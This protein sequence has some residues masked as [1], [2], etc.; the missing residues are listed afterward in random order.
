MSKKLAFLLTSMLSPVG[1]ETVFQHIRQLQPAHILSVTPHATIGRRYRRLEDTP[2]QRFKHVQ[3][4]AEGLLEVLTQAVKDRMRGA[5][6]GTTLSGGLDSGSITAI[7][8]SILEEQNK[9][10]PAF[11]HVPVFDTS[12]TVD[13]LRF[14]DETPYIMATADYLGNVD[15]HLLDSEQYSPLSAIREK[16]T[17]H[18][19]PE[20]AACNLFWL[21]DLLRSAKRHG[22]TTLLTGQGGNATISWKGK[23]WISPGTSP[24]SLRDLRK[25]LKFEIVLPLL[26]NFALEVL[27]RRKKKET[28]WNHTAIHPDFA[29]R[30]DLTKSIENSVNSPVQ[31]LKTLKNPLVTRLAVIQPQSAHIGAF[32]KEAG[33]H[34]GIDVQDPTQDQR[35]V[36]YTLSIPNR[37][38]TANGIDR[39]VLRRAMQGLLP[40]KVLFNPRR[41]RQGSDLPQRLR[42]FGMEMDSALETFKK[43][44]RG[45]GTPQSSI[46]GEHLAGNSNPGVNPGPSQEIDYHT[47]PWS[48]GRTLAH[49]VLIY[50]AM[51]LFTPRYTNEPLEIDSVSHEGSIFQANPRQVLIKIKDVADYLV[52]AGSKVT[53]RP[54]PSASE[55]DIR[56]FANGVVYAVLLL[57]RREYLPLHAGAIETP[58]GAILVCGASGSGKSTLI[59][60][61]VKRGFRFLSDDT[62]PVKVNEKGTVITTPYLPQLKLPQTAAASLGFDTTGMQPIRRDAKVDKLR[63]GSS[64]FLP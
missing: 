20:H 29:R 58:Q 3:D 17:F 38:F 6:V 28:T 30:I 1:N 5:A 9:R 15:P 59:A 25:R 26:P 57:Q 49:P 23:P 37:F 55:Q 64:R 34:F 12:G 27:F 19:T 13:A 16:L 8:S 61:F 52:E 21:L 2:L 33:H 45:P 10:L 53:I 47:D 32:W 60:S 39:F 31:H 22:I 44:P 62:S 51:M 46:A 63:S 35:V 18:P 4:A 56:L 36:A 7:S 43:E 24:E 14:G 40:E 11:S 48:D 41:G 42:T 54:H 50:C